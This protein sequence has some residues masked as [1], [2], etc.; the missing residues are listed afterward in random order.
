MAKHTILSLILVDF[1]PIFFILNLFWRILRG[2]YPFKRN[3]NLNRRVGLPISK[4]RKKPARGRGSFPLPL[5]IYFPLYFIW[6][7]DPEKDLFYEKVIENKKYFF[8]LNSV[9]IAIEPS[10]STTSW[11]TRASTGALT[12]TVGLVL[13]GVTKPTLSLSGLMPR[14]L[15][16][17]TRSHD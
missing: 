3:S 12:S 15:A 4:R 6:L 2:S 1:V 8:C 9:M 17:H 10:W 14:R 5:F 16:I 11:M 7:Y 13:S